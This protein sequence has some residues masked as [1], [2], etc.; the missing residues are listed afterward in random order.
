MAAKSLEHM[1]LEKLRAAVLAEDKRQEEVYDRWFEEIMDNLSAAMKRSSDA[2]AEFCGQTDRG[3]GIVCAALVEGELTRFII[4][5]LVNGNKK[6]RDRKH[7]VRSLF[8]RG[9]AM[10]NFGSQITLAYAMGLVSDDVYHDLDCIRELRN[11]FAHAIWY[12]EKTKKGKR[13]THD[14]V[15]FEQKNIKRLAISLKYP[16]ALESLTE[17]VGKRC[18]AAIRS[19][20]QQFF[21]ALTPRARYEITC[22]TLHLMLVTG[23]HVA[24]PVPLRYQTKI[25]PSQPIATERSSG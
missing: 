23:Q 6:T 18:P 3:A 15:T 17:D 10:E 8:D 7:K 25:L 22:E 14:S 20:P 5:H 1:E 2:Q 11:D 21:L 9:Q 16:K 24:S 4:A 12:V 19:D 13:Q